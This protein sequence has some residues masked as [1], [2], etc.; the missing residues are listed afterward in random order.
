MNMREFDTWISSKEGGKVNLPIAQ[1]SEVR[2]WVLTGL[3]KHF[4]S[5]EV[6][7]LA[8]KYSKKY[9]GK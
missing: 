5:G 4:K 7:K 2:K 1:I 8:Y 3:G 9:G 6:L